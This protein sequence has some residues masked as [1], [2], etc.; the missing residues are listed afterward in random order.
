MDPAQA[1]NVRIAVLLIC[2]VCLLSSARELRNAMFPRSV[3]HTLPP[4]SAWSDFVKAERRWAP[5]RAYLPQNA[6]VGYVSDASGERLG[7][8][9]DLAQNVLAPCI[10]TVGA[11]QTYVVGHFHGPIPGVSW[12]A[13]RNLALVKDFGNGILLFRRME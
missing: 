9:Y 8:E 4:G 5:V 7:R 6:V 3:G 13:V 12:L 11:D 2:S 10:L 1:R